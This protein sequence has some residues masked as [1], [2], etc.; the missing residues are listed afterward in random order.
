[1]RDREKGRERV[2]VREREN[3]DTYFSLLFFFTSFSYIIAS[4]CNFIISAVV[5]N[6]FLFLVE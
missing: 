5:V 2:R 1:M 6:L 4:K 3:D